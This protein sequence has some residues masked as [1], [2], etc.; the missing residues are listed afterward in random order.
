M[1]LVPYVWASMTF[2]PLSKWSRTVKTD[3][4]TSGKGTWLKKGG[5]GRFRGQCVKAYLFMDENSQLDFPYKLILI[6]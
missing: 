3:D 1:L 6:Y 4:V 2:L 5:Y